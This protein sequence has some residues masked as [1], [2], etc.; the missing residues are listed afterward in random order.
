MTVGESKTDRTPE[1]LI[2]VAKCLFATK[3]FSATTVREIATEAKVNLS[4]VSYHFDGKEGL[5]RACIEQFTNARV[6]DAERLLL[7]PT[8]REEFRIRLA[9]FTSEI[10]RSFGE[11]PEL[12]M[13]VQR[14]IEAENPIV[15]DI[16]NKTLLKVAMTLRGYLENA[17]KSGWVREGLD[18]LVAVSMIFGTMSHSLRMSH[19]TEKVFHFSIRQEE[20]RKHYGAQLAAIVM[21]GIM[22]P[23]P[24]SSEER[25]Q[26]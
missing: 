24:N 18:P 1:I 8:S 10:L 16:F 13:L 12:S 5:Y 15:K 9:M 14:E 11:E 22:G 7:P 25:L 3:G 17:Q 2:T 23:S 4:L 26:P 21:D 19:V 6:S 20:Y